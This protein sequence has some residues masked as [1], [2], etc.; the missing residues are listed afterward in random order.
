V[1]LL[2]VRRI[3]SG[4]VDEVFTE[5]NLRQT[6]GGRVA[7]LARDEAAEPVPIHG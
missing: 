7:F 5:D 4:P 3:A 1:T 6:Y 2:N